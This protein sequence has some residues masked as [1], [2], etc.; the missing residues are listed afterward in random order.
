MRTRDISAS[1][2]VAIGAAGAS[3]QISGY[4]IGNSLTW[5][6]R[7]DLMPAVIAAQGFT[8][9]TGYHIN[10]N[11]SLDQIAANPT[12]VCVPVVPEFGYFQ[13]ALGGV[14]LDYFTVQPFWT[15]TSTLGS[16][17]QVITDMEA[18]VPTRPDGPDTTL[19]LYQA[20]GSQSVMTDGSWLD[21]VDDHPDTL[22]QPQREYF[23]HLFAHL[24][25]AIDRPVRLIPVGAV[26]YEINQRIV[27]NEIPAVTDLEAFYRDDIH[28]SHGLGRFTADAAALCVIFNIP[29]FGM[30]EAWI[31]AATSGGYDTETFVAIENAIWDV[32]AADERTGV[33]PCLADTNRDGVVTP[34]DFSAWIIAYT[35]GSTA[36]DQ[37][38][39]GDITPSDFTAWIN[40]FNTPCD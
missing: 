11:R 27:A 33:S 10:C 9:E 30:H 31:D 21:D 17:I 34:A 12:Q 19:F 1:F 20:W 8:L 39:D 37:N 36:A 13:D 7:P 40:N 25:A 4:H 24:D 3:A 14:D 2:C 22:S 5:D 6:S 18:L 26:I 32:I 23:T 29:P 35:M 38:R 15:P 16:D 28:M